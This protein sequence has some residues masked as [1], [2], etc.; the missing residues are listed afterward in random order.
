M[1]IGNIEPPEKSCNHIKIDIFTKCPEAMLLEDIVAES[2]VIAFLHRWMP[3]FDVATQIKTDQRKRFEF[4]VL[5]EF[6][7]MLGSK[8]VHIA[9][10]HPQSNGIED[11][12]TL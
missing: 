6:A 5:L 11:C 10:Y 4:S 7:N 3:R 9:S 12:I 1:Q 2:V 8:V